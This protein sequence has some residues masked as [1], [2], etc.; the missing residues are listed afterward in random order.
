M[1]NLEGE[2]AS[3]RPLAA[4]IDTLYAQGTVDWITE[5]QD[6]AVERLFALLEQNQAAIAALAQA[7]RHTR[8]ALEL[9]Q[10]ELA[11]TKR[12]AAAER[13]IHGGPPADEPPPRSHAAA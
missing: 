2:R 8:R 7:W 1:A 10:A 11:Y 13:L 4:A 9:S 12:A 3:D 5:H 6:A